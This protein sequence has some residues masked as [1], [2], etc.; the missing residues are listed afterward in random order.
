MRTSGYWARI[1]V[2]IA[3]L[4]LVSGQANAHDTTSHDGTLRRIRVPILMYHYI[5]EL[6]TNA[7]KYRV[8]LTVTP[9]IF[10]AHMAYLHDNGYETISLDMLD[11]ALRL[12]TPLPSKPIVLT[13]DD[14]HLDHY[15]NAYPILQEFS[16]T[17]T[18]FVIT[19][20]LD[21]RHPDY[22]NWEQAN[23]MKAAGMH[24]EPHTK[25]HLE[26]DNRSRDFVVYE[27][28][29]SIESV[30]AHIGQRPRNFSYPVGRYDDL[31]LQVMQE[32]AIARAVTTQL[33]SAHTTTNRLEVSR[34]RVT[35]NMNVQGLRHLL[36]NY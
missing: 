26:L 28:L 22:I 3:V 4:G 12:G 24:I 1:L 35:G 17:G 32:A 6:P 10:H 23:E 18:F 34:L 30:E 21:N 9:D 16:F 20:L 33:G 25:N 15:T 19:G 31:T 7:D 27:V 11:D 2:C 5:S 36:Q 13:F 14:G 29:G 8:E